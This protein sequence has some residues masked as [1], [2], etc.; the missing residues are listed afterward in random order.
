MDITKTEQVTRRPDIVASHAAPTPSVADFDTRWAAWVARGRAH[1]E[2]VRRAF[3][4]WGVA[5]AT[6]SAIVYALLRT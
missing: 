5:I 2:R 6:G 3:V 1:D 4:G